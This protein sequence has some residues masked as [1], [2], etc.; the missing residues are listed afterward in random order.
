M[1]SETGSDLFKTGLIRGAL[2]AHPEARR[3]ITQ[4][5]SSR[6]LFIIFSDVFGR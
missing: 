4:V 2:P 6:N 3:S 5:Q 1:I